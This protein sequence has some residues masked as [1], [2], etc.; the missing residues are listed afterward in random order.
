VRR[1]FTLS[2]RSRRSLDVALAL[3]LFAG[4]VAVAFTSN[5]IEGPRWLNCVALAPLTLSLVVRRT[6]P[7]VTV[8][9]A[10]TAGLVMLAFLTPPPTFPFATFS[11]M[12]AS[13]SAGVN[14]P[15]REARIA[16]ALVLGMILT[17]CIVVTPYDIV[18]PVAIFGLL[19]WVG[20]RVLRNHTL[21]T[22]ELAE[23][24]ELAAHLGESGERDAVAAERVRVA[25]ELHDVLA[26]DL[27]VM[28]IQAQGAQRMVDRD[29]AAAADA[30]D[31]IGQTGRD[32]LTELRRLFGAVRHGE[33]EDLTGP[34]GLD[35]LDALVG[36]ARAAGLPVTVRREGE[37][38]R[39]APGLDIAAYRI[40]Q[41]ALTNTYK[42]AGNAR[43]IVTVTS[44]DHLV[45]I[46]VVDDG[47]GPS[48][49]GAALV[50]GGHGLVGM[51]ERVSVYGGE[52]EAGPRQGG[53]FRVVAR[54]PVERGKVP[55]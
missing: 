24:A 40:I 38:V 30:A 15:I 33:G 28:V 8:A 5:D 6:R 10:C 43:A 36:R 46:E 18:F 48:D 1:R 35:Q 53:G 17:A 22:R 4:G 51:R 19:P 7:L 49:E 45:M 2:D 50:S 13:Y 39:L 52:V 29:P 26:H 9:I 32:A 55:A 21:L 37:P 23:K 20:G 34:P 31:L 42:H 25:R 27:S 54:L 41:E 16:L 14:A 47:H 44:W 12:I 3:L 11:L